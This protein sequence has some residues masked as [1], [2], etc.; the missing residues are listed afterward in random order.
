MLM[1]VCG[2]PSGDRLGA[3]LMGGLKSLAGDAIR[4]VGVGGPAMAA[5]GLRSERRCRPSLRNGDTIFGGRL[6]DRRGRS[7]QLDPIQAT[8]QGLGCEISES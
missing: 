4:V 7:T 3:E 6:P 5:Q 2:E 1:L 8:D